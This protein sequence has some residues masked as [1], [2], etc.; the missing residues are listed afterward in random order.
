MGRKEVGSAENGF[1]ANVLGLVSNA[2]LQEGKRFFG[3]KLGGP[4]AEWAEGGGGDEMVV[5]VD[6]FFQEFDIW[7]VEGLVE[8]EGFKEMEWF[9]E[10]SC[11][12]LKGFQERFPW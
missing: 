3:R 11:P 10:S 12:F 9:C 2:V 5:A 6:E 1:A 4:E 7:F 8:P